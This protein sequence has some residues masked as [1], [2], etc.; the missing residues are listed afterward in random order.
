[1]RKIDFVEMSSKHYHE[2]KQKVYDVSGKIKPYKE[3]IKGFALSKLPENY[4]RSLSH[5]LFITL[6]LLISN[7]STKSKVTKL[8]LIKIIAI[9]NWMILNNFRKHDKEEL[10]DLIYLDSLTG[11]PNRRCFMER[12]DIEL[13]NAREHNTTLALLFI[14]LD[15]FKQINDTFGHKQGDS[16][17]DTVANRLTTLLSNKT[18][19]YRLAGDEFTVLINDTTKEEAQRISQNI[20]KSLSDKMYIDEYDLSVTPS[21]G[22]CLYPDFAENKEELIEHADIAMYTAKEKGKNTYC[23]FE[24]D[25]KQVTTR[26]VILTKSLRKAIV[27]NEFILH[28]QPQ[29]DIDSGI[30]KGVEALIRWEHTKLGSIS[31]A[32]FIPLAEEYGLI[33]PISEW[34]VHEACRQNKQWQDDGLQKVCV[35]V[36]ISPLHLSRHDFTHFIEEVL[37]ETGLDPQ[38]LEVEVTEGITLKIDNGVSTLNKLQEIGVKIAIDDFGTGYSS[39][40]YIQKLPISALKIDRSFITDINWNK[41]HQEITNSIIVMANSLNIDVTAEGIET[42]DQ[43][44]YLKRINCKYAQGYLISKPIPADD[45]EKLLVGRNDDVF[46]LK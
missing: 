11:L 23:F 30:L 40:K 28:Y 10:E 45:V 41:N 13:D 22:I 39:L 38:F 27:K 5:T 17:L 12:L 25:L 16:L 6:S 9:L 15:G 29:I 2:L 36:N 24:S 7:H 46:L 43:L 1:M 34:V 14:D 33:I 26:E 8:F 42:R 19:V 4:L 32:E 44:E 35:A 37:H 21:I 18:E 3:S 31:P 20:L